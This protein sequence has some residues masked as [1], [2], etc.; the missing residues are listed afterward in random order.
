MSRSKSVRD[1]VTDQEPATVSALSQEQK[2]QYNQPR[3]AQK[4]PTR[5][6][7]KSSYNPCKRV[8]NMWRK[9][10]TKK[11]LKTWAREH[12]ADANVQ[13]WMKSKGIQ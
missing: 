3:E 4:L 1:I 7:G 10:H 8:K 11:S 2:E 5:G 12:K 6:A 9:A 13:D